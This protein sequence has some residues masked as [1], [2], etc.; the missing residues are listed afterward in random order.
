MVVWIRSDRCEIR[1]HI[2]RG[3]YSRLERTNLVRDFCK[4]TKKGSDVST[5]RRDNFSPATKRLL[6]DR[7]A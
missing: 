6:A 7:A 3:A 2:G 1:T 5:N 4:P